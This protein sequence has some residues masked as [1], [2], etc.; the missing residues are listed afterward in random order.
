MN[1]KAYKKLIASI[2]GVGIIVVFHKYDITLPG[3]DA[4]VMDILIGAGTS[5]GVYQAT[6]EA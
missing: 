2:V 6:N 1:W 5:F 3:L 4:F